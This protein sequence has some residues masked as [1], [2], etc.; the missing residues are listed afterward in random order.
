MYEELAGPI[1]ARPPLLRLAWRNALRNIRR[2]VL[3]CTAVIV[4]VTAIVFMLAY[5]TGILTNIQD[6][7]ARH[8]TGHARITRQGY[9]ERERFSPLY[10]NV[11]EISALVPA[12]RA[13]PDVVT[14]LPRIRS[15]AL[16]STDERNATALVV[17]LDLAGEE[18]YMDPARMVTAGR[19]PQ[20]GRAEV[21]VGEGL[22]D[23][24]RLVP[25]DSLTLLGQTAWRSFGGLYVEVA[26]IGRSGMA[27]MDRALVVLP[28]DQAQL[29]TELDDAAT[30]VLVFTHSISLAGALASTLAN[31]IPELAGDELET[32]SL[33][34]ESALSAMTQSTTIAYSVF[35]ILLL[36]MAGLI[37]VN[38]MLMTVLERTR[39][40]GMLAAMGM[41]RGSAV[42]LILLEGMVI[43]I[44]G[45][46]IG[47]ALGTGIS[48]WVGA[49]GIDFTEA[50]KS[51]DMP[52]QGILYPSWHWTHLLAASML[53]LLTATV[54]TLYPAWR[55]VR[56]APA[57]ALRK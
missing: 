10:L 50:M 4:S 45:A 28:L 17:G 30:E 12:L 40:L 53:G 19:L 26:G 24:L 47:G 57:D 9:L 13:H 34:S 22:A 52:F 20:P 21:L 44:L 15:A 23:K 7:Y 31:D 35:L 36:T 37:I 18:G 1:V 46:A 11:P 55:A 14:V 27:Y 56:L 3:T 49:V 6:S 42:R 5:I 8:V 48:L 25:G 54:A 32:R 39:E 16:A 38:T 2:T 51:V 41:R 33:W 29:L 43:G